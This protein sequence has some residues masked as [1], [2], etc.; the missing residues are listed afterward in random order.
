[1]TEIEKEFNIEDVLGAMINRIVSPQ[2]TERGTKSIYN[3]LE[4]MTGEDIFPHEFSVAFGKCRP[5]L[6]KQ[7]PQ[8]K[9]PEMDLE[10]AELDKMRE[11]A[12][13]EEERK[14]YTIE[15]L[16]RQVAKHGETF[17]VRSIP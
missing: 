7:F 15:W 11:A 12:K 13:T 2:G 14:L 3:L 8:L 17:A 9:T 10:V 6:F 4:F 5:Y 1:M 16:A